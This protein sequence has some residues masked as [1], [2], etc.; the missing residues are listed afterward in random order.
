LGFCCER[1]G[2]C[3]TGTTVIIILIQFP[4]FF[5]LRIPNS[6][7]SL[8]PEDG[9][10]HLQITKEMEERRKLE[11]KILDAVLLVNEA[12]ALSSSELSSFKDCSFELKLAS[13]SLSTSTRNLKDL[14]NSERVIMILLKMIFDI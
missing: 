10:N 4:S 11:E 9:G 12:N 14:M 3:T 5:A 8:N 7:N 13:T 2:N 1:I 6:L